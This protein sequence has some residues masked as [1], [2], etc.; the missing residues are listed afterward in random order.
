MK[1]TI[2]LYSLTTTS[3]LFCQYV[4]KE[5]NTDLNAFGDYFIQQITPFPSTQSFKSLPLAKGFFEEGILE[6]EREKVENLDRCEYIK[7]EFALYMYLKKYEISIEKFKTKNTKI[8]MEILL[9]E[10]IQLFKK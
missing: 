1:K 5:K 7:K 6:I 8:D 3:L 2:V 4:P 10:T 9:R